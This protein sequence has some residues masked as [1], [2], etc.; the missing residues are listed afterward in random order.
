[1]SRKHH[2]CR[3]GGRERR[4]R[5]GETVEGG[6]G[7]GMRRGRREGVRVC[8]GKRVG[9]REPRRGGWRGC[10]WRLV[11]GGEMGDHWG[12]RRGRWGVRQGNGQVWGGVVGSGWQESH[13]VKAAG[14][15]V[16]GTPGSAHQ[17]LLGVVVQ[18]GDACHHTHGE[19]QPDQT[20]RE[21][22]RT[23]DTTVMFISE[24]V[25]VGLKRPRKF[26]VFHRLP[27]TSHEALVKLNEKSPYIYD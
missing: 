14:V 8:E 25:P 7:R 13:K 9:V 1:M 15:E 12:G 23:G 27:I 22:T 19:G 21:E 2:A 24:S 4:G 5:K 20:D 10:R 16:R 6:R 18:G 17:D 11:V 3:D 26:L